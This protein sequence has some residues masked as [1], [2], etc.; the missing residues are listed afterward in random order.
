MSARAIAAILVVAA[1]AVIPG[2]A[3]AGGSDAGTRSP[4][5]APAGTRGIALGGAF[6]AVPGDV[7]IGAWN[8]GGLGW[9]AR[10]E[11]SAS[12]VSYDLG[13]REDFATFAFPSW[14]LGT[15]SIA[16]RRFG[17]DGID[18]RDE[19]NVSTGEDFSSSE[20]EVSVAYGRTFGTLVG[21]G[22]AV[23]MQR[24][25]VA[26]QSGSGLGADLGVTLYPL[27]ALRMPVRWASQVTWGLGIR[28]LV[29][30][31]IR[32]DEESV[33]DPSTRRMGFAYRTAFGL[34]TLD[35]E[36]GGGIR[37]RLHAGAEFAP[38][39]YLSVRAG[40]NGGALTAG[41]GF[42][43][44]GVALDY[45]FEDRGYD[46][47]H[48]VGLSYAFGPT[49]AERRDAALR[50]EDEKL[51][52]RLAETF[53]R[54][55][56]EKVRGLLARAEEARAA[57]SY[58]EALEALATIGTLDPDDPEAADLEIRC[59]RE[60]GAKFEQ[61]GNLAEAA[62]AYGRILEKRPQDPD[63]RVAQGRCRAESDR[64]AARSA[65]IRKSFAQAMDAFASD[66]L[67][68]ARDGFTAI[69]RETPNDDDARA[70]LRRTQTALSRRAQ[71]IL[72]DARRSLAD[73]HFD[74]A[75]TQLQEARGLDPDADGL[76]SLSAALERARSAATVRT[77]EPARQA[78]PPAPAAS[79]LSPGELREFYRR[80][81]SALAQKRSADALRYFELVW[82]AD[83]KYQRVAEY[84]EREYLIQGLDAYAA[85]RLDE[86]IA[87]W[88]RA[89][90]VDPSDPRARGYLTRAQQQLE[91]SREMAGDAP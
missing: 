49:T 10:G 75:A 83:P 59:L 56:R 20:T 29:E 57:G 89:L 2:H 84:L 62:V 76:A 39:P 7:T 31:R 11:A 47:I 32:L 34:A 77:P 87:H 74:A 91:R 52:A 51:Q 71:G 5:A 72:R 43:A 22:G 90:A 19:R 78:P 50:A 81:L 16:F 1:L 23:K 3:R 68:A 66:N 54:V 53:Q 4:F 17:T 46:P 64:R 12:T 42:R 40:M 82:S 63:A 13:F 25:S 65:E 37:P 15:G 8:P 55:Q 85:G 60:Q 58:A 35:I 30:P 24:Q 14:R 45:A 44:R 79:T 41:A 33:G 6:V 69:L 73:R 86:A 36:T 27:L 18:G 38:R 26:G 28:N 48:R 21:V 61:E 9:V 88:E 67:V 80:A 70:M